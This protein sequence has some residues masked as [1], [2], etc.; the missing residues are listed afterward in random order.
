MANSSDHQELFDVLAALRLN[1]EAIPW[2]DRRAVAASLQSDLERTDQRE[3]AIELAK[4]FS[5]DPKWEVRRE[6]ATLMI[7]MPDDEFLSLAATLTRD[8]NGYVRKAAERALDLRRRGAREP[9]SRRKGLDHVLSQFELIE[10]THGKALSERARSLAMQLYEVSVAASVHDLRGVLTSALSKVERLRNEVAE[11]VPDL[12]K[13]VDAIDTVAQRLVYI[14]K[15][16]N[17]MGGFSQALTPDRLVMPLA[18]VVSQARD[19]VLDGFDGSEFNFSVS[20]DDS[21]LVSAAPHL[22]V[23]AIA[24]ILKNACEAVTEADDGRAKNVTLIAEHNGDT[25]IRIIIRDN[26]IGVRG[27]DLRE[28]KAFVPGRT[29][30]KG[31]GTGFGL[32]IAQRYLAAH[33]GTISIESL[34]NVGTTVSIILPSTTFSGASE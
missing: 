4:I 12:A 27:D 25:D 9:T 16:V 34:E 19:V 13:I 8:S 6:I 3:V 18:R 22:L 28:L 32:P 24:N 20:V 2:A 15:F 11:A 30:K 10:A 1:R 5:A 7:V 31:R 26:G 29:T 14:E 33:G 23:T 17:G 21:I